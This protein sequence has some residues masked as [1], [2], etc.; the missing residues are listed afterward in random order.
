MDTLIGYDANYFDSVNENTLFPIDILSL[1]QSYKSAAVINDLDS[2][3]AGKIFERMETEVAAKILTAQ[4]K[5][6][7]RGN[8][9]GILPPPET[10]VI[11][12]EKAAEI[13]SIMKADD[14]ANILTAVAKI[15]PKRAAAIKGAMYGIL[16]SS[17]TIEEIIDLVNAGNPGAAARAVNS[18]NTNDFV[19]AVYEINLWRTAQI[20]TAKDRSGNYILNPEKAAEIMNAMDIE[21]RDTLLNVIK[22]QGGQVLYL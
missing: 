17:N 21:G 7:C 4:P 22:A 3:V 9:C 12:T 18:I 5:A 20:F 15:N 6:P 11:T 1:L 10:F 13:L 8:T 16:G 2:E 19:S 14:S